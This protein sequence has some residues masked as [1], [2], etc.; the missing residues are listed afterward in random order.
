[1]ISRLLCIIAFTLFLSENTFSQT[2][3][4]KGIVYD[5]ETREKL[6]GAT[7]QLVG[8]LSKGA[9]TDIDG[10]YI[11]EIDTGYHQLVCN[12][13]GL[14]TYT[15]S[16]HITENGVTEQ[17]VFLKS[18]AKSLETIVVSSG[19]FDQK[20]EDITVSM[21]ILKPK[22]ISAKNTTSIETALEQVPGL[23]IID[24]DPQ[25]RGGSGFTFGVGSRVAIL[26]DGI[27]MLSGDA[28]RPEWSYLP[29]EN[30][31]QVE[32]IKGVS[33]VLY[34]SSALN[35]VINIRTAYPRSKP[36]TIISISGGEY[37]LPQAPA[38]SWYNQSAPA[39]ANIN[40]MHSRVIKS[41][42]D[43][44]IGGNF[45]ADQGYIGPPPAAPY[46]P[47]DI[48][49]AFH[50]LNS[51]DS[52]HTYT[53]KDM[54]KI[55]GR[56]NFN[57]RYRS[58]RIT[59]LNYGINGNG[60]LN[61]TNMVLAWLN[62]SNGLYKGY[63]GAVFLE[64][65]SIFNI[66]PFIK[67][68]T[69]SGISHSLITRIFH[70][71]NQISNNQSNSGT[72]YFGEYQI[73][74]SLKSIGLTFTGGLVNN[75]SS[76]YSLLYASSGTLDNKIQNNAGYAQLDY[77]LWHIINLSGGFRYEYYKLNNQQSATAPII[78]GGANIQL[79]KATFLR[80]S[81]GQGFRY[82]TITERFL[83]TQA[84]MLAVFPNPNLVPEKSQ[85]FEIGVKQGFKIGNFKGYLDAAAFNQTYENTIEFLFGNWNP[86]IALAGFEFVNTGRSQANGL[87]F[88]L[89]AT[90]P[91]TNK[92]FG[93]TALIGYTYV[94]PIS[95]TPNYVYVHD[96]G[97]KGLSYANTSLNPTGDV[98]KYRY[99]H[100][101][102]ADVEFKI[103]RFTLGGSYRYY[104]KMQN[105]DTAFKEL[106]SL[107]A[108][109]QTFN[110]AYPIKITKFWNAHN[111][112]NVFDLRIGFKISST[113]KVSIVC[114]NVMN[115]AYML[116]PMKI[117]PPRT[118]MVQ[119]MLEF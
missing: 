49:Q 6:P 9:A 19:K 25:I 99:K 100:M 53:N 12:F 38:A 54:L 102:K 45:N 39:L 63:P 29:V 97:G 26:L 83:T 116:R 119:Y 89:A 61:K 96:A 35:G 34:G 15:F 51:S 82:P 11:L 8:N 118:T 3:V 107:T 115:T 73:Q 93:A 72:S 17:D 64:H 23:S 13:V 27:P 114:N 41:N 105:I 90:T 2:G 62:D 42:L 1:M 88:S 91:E 36:K 101:A 33:S 74:R 78:R 18:A 104:S 98:M 85:S 31:E 43:F 59:G 56:V 30:I 28:G 113:Q 79:L 55:R 87:D 84:G 111:G 60:M 44:V 81:G 109:L 80:L 7:I 37:S 5:F 47:W 57:L 68:S 16:V 110:Y 66:D 94:D 21:E 50:L 108:L 92:R 24:N 71:D 76:S 20:I 112:F 95:L 48:K 40:F 86:S 4:L 52:I 103:Y 69:S 14:K 65:Q 22:L 75:T 67:Y 117:E 77:K 70:T 46:L 32:V 10:H 106:E 58:K